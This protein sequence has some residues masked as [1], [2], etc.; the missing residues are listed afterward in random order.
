[1][2]GYL[3]SLI[4]CLITMFFIVY[5]FFNKQN[6]SQEISKINF[7]N[8]IKQ[9]LKKRKNEVFNIKNQPTTSN[10]HKKIKSQTF[11]LLYIKK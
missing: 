9:S 10:Y 3:F 7:K 6:K 1:M 4:F 2:Y 11:F 5:I 8:I